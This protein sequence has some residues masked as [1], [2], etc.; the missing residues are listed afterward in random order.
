M[1]K[2]IFFSGCDS[3]Y[4]K[5]YG[6][7]FVKSF[8]H[9]NQ[10]SQIFIQLFNPDKDDLK[11]IKSLPCNFDVFYFDKLYIKELTRLHIDLYEN[12]AD[13]DLRLKLKTG[14]KFSEK[15]YNYTDLY[16]KMQ[17]LMTFSVFA[18]NRFIKLQEIWNGSVPIAAYDIDSICQQEISIQSMLFN[19]NSGCLNVK[20]DRFV[21]SLVAFQKEK[22]F[23]NE[24]ATSLQNCFKSNSVYGFMDQDTFTIL[25]SKHKVKKID[26]LYCDHT[27]KAGTSKVVTGKGHTK[28][29]DSFNKQLLLWQ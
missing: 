18:S 28:W 21:V 17:H 2:Q 1:H 4:W 12:K 29:S 16:D 3:S 10:D 15:N 20:G 24:W 22:T 14:M 25:A 19:Y 26:R 5:K 6:V 7:P 8:K 9:F 23:L 11:V 27:K 13:A